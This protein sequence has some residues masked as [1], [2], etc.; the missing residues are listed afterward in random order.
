MKIAIAGAGAMG[1]RFGFMLHEAG[2]DVILIDEWQEHIK[3][4]GE[5]G[6]LVEKDGQSFQAEI[7]IFHPKEVAETKDLV[8]IFTKSM[9]LERMLKNI[10]A[11]IGPETKILCL[12]NGVGHEAILQQYVPLENIIM[13]VTILTSKLI[14]PGKISFAGG[15]LT[16][17]QNFV[18]NE[19]AKEFTQRIV[20]LLNKTGLEVEY[21][22]DVMYSIWRKACVNGAMNATCALLDC[23]LAEFESVQP[24]GA[25][26]RSIVREFV[27]AA[28]D[29]GTVLNE[30]DIVDYIINSAKAVGHHYPSM[31]QDLVQNK[32]LTEVDFLNGAVARMAKEDGKEAPVNALIAQLIHAKEEIIQAK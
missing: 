15:G 20:K 32:R 7:P 3:Q 18:D 13:G 14:G 22:D 6:L 29:R 21:S 2:E 5:N 31:H 9:H 8:I 26:I 4:I 12:L 16:E 19:K 30:D 17:I 11:V 23:N 10:S 1:S 27:D 24:S 28:N 25:I